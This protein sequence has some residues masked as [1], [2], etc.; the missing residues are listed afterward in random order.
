MLKSGVEGLGVE[1]EKWVE[2]G[3]ED[4]RWGVG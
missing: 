2:K 1:G 3:V 4:R